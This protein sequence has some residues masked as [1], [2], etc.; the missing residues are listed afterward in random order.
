MGRVR[1]VYVVLVA[2]AV[3]GLTACGGGQSTLSPASPQQH[4][5]SKLF[6]IMLAVAWAGFALIVGLLTLGWVHR[7]ERRPA[8]RGRRRAGDAARD[9]ARRRHAD[10]PALGALRLVGPVRDSSRPPR[11]TPST[12]PAEDPDR[13]AT[14]GSGR[15]ATRARSAVTANEIHIPTGRARG[16]R[17][18]DGGR[19]PQLLGA[20]A[21]PKDRP[22]PR[23]AEPHPARRLPSRASTAGSASS[24]AACSTRTWH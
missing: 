17:R 9:R 13:S 18:A 20:E 16:R 5:I 19:D 6:W 15:R 14:S 1:R 12:T 2:L 4:E 24:S 11:P 23:P 10:R 3:L 8:L 21:E 22:D 7:R